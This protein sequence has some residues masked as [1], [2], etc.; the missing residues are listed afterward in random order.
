MRRPRGAGASGGAG[1]R[2]GYNRRVTTSSRSGRLGAAVLAVAI[3]WAAWSLAAELAALRRQVADPPNPGAVAEWT[4]ATPRME[5]L[6]RFLRAA[7]TRLPD[8]R[9]VAFAS[10]TGDADQEFFLALW[11]AYLLPEERV[12]RLDGPVERSG[13]DYLLTYN[14][15]R[16]DPHLEE[17]LRHPSGALY[18]ILPQ[19]PAAASDAGVSPR[20]DAGVER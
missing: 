13:A 20:A 12:L 11:A 10:A 9:V 1:V 18:R 14:T 7:R 8:G 6:R 3:A 19:P 17:L 2:R 16:D 5:S 4:L 15:T